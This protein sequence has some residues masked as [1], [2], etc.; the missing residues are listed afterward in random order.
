LSRKP[1]AI[2]SV[3]A[4]RGVAW[5]SEAAGLIRRQ[6]AR[7]MLLGLVLQFLMGFSQVGILALVLILT[8]PAFTAGMM[9]AMRLAEHGSRPPLAALFAAFMSGGKLGRLVALGAIMLAGG[10]LA[11]M[12]VLSGS[13]AAL[14]PGVLARL[15]SGDVSVLEAI[16][17]G[18]RQRLMLSMLAGLLV[19]ASVSY[20]AVPLIW[21]GDQPLGRAIALGLLGMLRNWRPFFVLG[22]LIAALGLPVALLT[23]IV[24]SAAAAGSPAS[25]VLS[26]L[27]LLIVVVFQLILFGTQ[28]CAFRDVF[29][30]VRP[31]EAEDRPEPGDQLVA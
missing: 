2:R 10:M 20:F 27:M 21:F 28:Y 9:A 23:A 17:P 29:G 7:L 12:L 11:V 13:L 4:A 31:R 3:P 16:D 1:S 19:S 18:L 15:E 14:D 26:V 6:P 5:L 30:V 22:L 24:F 25:S 8:I